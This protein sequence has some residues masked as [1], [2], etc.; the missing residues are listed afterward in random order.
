MTERVVPRLI[1]FVMTFSFLNVMASEEKEE[2]TVVVAD[3]LEQKNRE[4][5]TFVSRSKFF[6]SNLYENI[7]L[8]CKKN[9][10]ADNLEIGLSLG[11][12]GLGIEASTP[13]TRWA[14]LRVGLEWMPNIKTSLNFNL[15]TYS[16]GMPTGSFNHVAEMLYDMTGIQMDEKVRMNAKGSMVN[17]KFLVD[18]FPIPNNNHWHLTAGF[19]V[20]TSK[21][22]TAINDINEKPTLVGLNIYNRAYEYFTTLNSIYD[23]PLGGGVYM[24]PDLVR[25]LQQRFAQYGRMGVQVGYFNKDVG[26]DEKGNPI[27]K[28]GDPYIMEPA[29]DGT[30]SAK[31][32]VNRFKPYL[33]A[34]YSTTFGYGKRWKFSVDLGAIFWGG[35]PNILNCDYQTGENINF[36]K[37]LYNI[38]G[39]IGDYMGKIKSFP[40][41]PALSVKIS[42]TLF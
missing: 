7:S 30:I 31:A 4:K 2:I 41:Y 22:G 9:N 29:P 24:D 12:T 25:D 32:V 17:F 33:G 8:W 26:K 3:S 42:Y 38:R 21:I 18:V 20:G 15:G 34:G 37:D 1:L 6:V 14:S 19:F 39:K 10:V 23:V 36:T 16:D 11:S 40:V 28:K 5:D 27:Y 35:S 13:V